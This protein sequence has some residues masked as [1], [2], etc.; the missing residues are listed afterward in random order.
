MGTRA[1]VPIRDVRS[2]KRG[3]RTPEGKE[4]QSAV[5]NSHLPG[6]LTLP[7]STINTAAAHT[8][9]LFLTIEVVEYFKIL[10][11]VFQR[12]LLIDQSKFMFFYL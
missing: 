11:A 5:E 7:N 4:R 10:P 1:N 6:S 9:R 8:L 3:D 12:Y 2:C